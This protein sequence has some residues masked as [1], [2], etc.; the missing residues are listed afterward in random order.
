M[1]NL[2]LLTAPLVIVGVFVVCHALGWPGSVSKVERPLDLP[3]MIANRAA[4]V[5]QY[6]VM[7]VR[8]MPS[9]VPFTDEQS[10]CVIEILSAARRVIEGTAGVEAE[11]QKVFGKGLFFW[12][13]NPAKPIKTLKYYPSENFRMHGISLSFERA[14]EHSPWAKAGLAIHPRNFPLGVFSMHLPPSVFD[15]F[16]LTKVTREQ[17]PDESIRDPIV[18]YF[19]HKRVR[20]LTLKV[21]SREDVVHV[22][23]TYPSSFHAIQ[24]MRSQ[25]E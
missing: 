15:N 2:L 25:M 13:K 21:E 22:D 11:E 7:D 18:F 4:I 1:R 16:R 19:E 12:P 14:S 20:G 17:R 8:Q 10:A 24:L 6:D 3:E 9:V 5:S 23:D